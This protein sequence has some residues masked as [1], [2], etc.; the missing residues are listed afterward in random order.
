MDIYAI[1]IQKIYRGYIVRSRNLPLILLY[2]REYLIKN[3]YKC[4][5][6]FKDGRTNSIVDEDNIINII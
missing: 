2:I 1:K 3:N 6:E 5:F 4:T